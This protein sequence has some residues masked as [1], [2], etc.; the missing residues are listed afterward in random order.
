[1]AI[2]D[3]NCDPD[4]VDFIIP[5][6][7]DAIRAIRLISSKIADACLEG[8]QIRE[9][10]LTAPEAGGCGRRN[11]RGETGA[12]PPADPAAASQETETEE[13]IGGL[14]V[15]ISATMV[16]DLREKTGAG[17]MDCKKALAES[18]GNF[19]KAVDYLRQKGLATAAKRAGRV[20]S[21]GRIGSYIHAG[22]KI[23][24]MVEV[25][26]E[27]DF[28]AKTD[29]F[30]AFA[31]DIAMQIAASNPL[32][33]R[34]EEV[35]PKPWKR[36]GKSTGSRPGKPESPRRSSTRSLTEN[37][38]NITAKSASWSSFSSKIP[39]SPSRTC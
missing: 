20:A 21:E 29:D 19:E 9:A 32:Y 1:M 17:M 11:G 33:V 24:V 31:K 22:G 28:V 38:K 4:E 16:R 12:R 30:Q 26:C 25:N 39:I 18:G 14:I 3:T 7:D 8:K 37:W 36:N 2:V 6:N 23:G 13:E 10:R 27:T 35:P 5:G 15:E 34:R